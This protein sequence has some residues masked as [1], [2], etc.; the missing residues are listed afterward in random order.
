MVARDGPRD[1]PTD[2]NTHGQDAL[3]DL[4]RTHVTAGG[5]TSSRN[6][7]HGRSE[8]PCEA[9]TESLALAQGSTRGRLR[10]TRT[11]AAL[12]VGLL[13]VSGV[14]AV[15]SLP[16]TTVPELAGVDRPVPPIVVPALPVVP[17]PPTVVVA[18]PPDPCSGAAEFREV[19]ESVSPAFAAGR[20][21][22]RF[23][24]KGCNRGIALAQGLIPEKD[25]LFVALLP[26]SGGRHVVD[27]CGQGT[28]CGEVTG[29]PKSLASTFC[30]T[31]EP[32]AAPDGGGTTERCAEG[33]TICP[34]GYHE[35]VV[36][37]ANPYGCDFD[38][39]SAMNPCMWR[40]DN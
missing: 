18:P 14:A 38:A 26:R 28:D 1:A 36:S 12:V 27:S 19:L 39:I 37:A 29:L 8:D 40:F 30:A 22:T 16:S 34:T 25:N 7:A 35:G 24:L 4:H 32:A 17:P 5:L 21:I 9:V 13:F 10:R 23:E 6:S 11:L 3:V 20:G 33:T 15:V 2:V 31:A